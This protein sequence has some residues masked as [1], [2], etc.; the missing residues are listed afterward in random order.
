MSL[1]EHLKKVPEFRAARGQHL[2]LRLVL[3]LI[4]LGAMLGD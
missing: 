3:L 1:I 4:I 2:E